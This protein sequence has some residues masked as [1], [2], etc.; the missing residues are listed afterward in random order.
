M[1]K[2]TDIAPV[3]QQVSKAV[4]AAESLK[5]TKAEDLTKAT[6]LLSKV[7]TVI[8]FILSKKDPQI[9]TAYKAYK[10]IKAQQEA[11]WDPFLKDMLAAEDIIKAK[12]VVFHDKE[13]KSADKTIEKIE[14]KFE[15][16]K[17]TALEANEKILAVTPA[18]NIIATQ[19]ASQFRSYKDIEGVDESLIP[20][21]FWELNIPRLR[22]AAL[23][24]GALP[25]PGVKV[26]EKTSVAGIIKK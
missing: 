15:N 20:E 5:I 3:K 14:E 12:M 21:E 8:K 24:P 16:K 1:K 13:I 9:K 22:K 11:T 19:G 23:T 2:E 17:I 18:Q 26:V 7:K 4:V 6:D 25:I 10:D